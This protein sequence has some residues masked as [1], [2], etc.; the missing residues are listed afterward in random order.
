[1]RS[2]ISCL[3]ISRLKMATDA[4]PVS[5]MLWAMFRA[6]EVLPT[7]GRAARTMRFDG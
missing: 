2:L 7:P 4:L 3:L 5:P 1:M 6:R